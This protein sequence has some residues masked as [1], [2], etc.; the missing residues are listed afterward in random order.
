MRNRVTHKPRTAGTRYSKSQL[1]RLAIS[2]PFKM[3]E[4]VSELYQ[5]QK[6][7]CRVLSWAMTSMLKKWL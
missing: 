7:R 5:T 4:Y 6:H 2:A 1:H 3:A